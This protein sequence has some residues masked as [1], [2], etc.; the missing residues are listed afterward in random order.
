[1]SVLDRGGRVFLVA[2]AGV[3]HLGDLEFAHRQVDAAAAAGVDAV[4]VQA[5]RT[6]ELVSS[7]AAARLAPDLGHDWYDRLRARELSA[8]GLQEL[9]A[10]AAERGLLFFATP[11]DSS[12]LS[13]VVETLDVPLLKVGSG[14]AVNWRFLR[15]VGA[16]RRPVLASFG[17]ASDEEARR[18]VAT[19]LEAGAPEV[20]ALHTVSVYPTP[21]RLASL[22]RIARLRRLLDVPVGLSDH[23]VGSHV[24]LASVALGVHTL[25]KH[26]TLDKADPRS[27]DNAGALEP[28][29]LA[30]LARQIREIEAALAEPV[31][32][33]LRAALAPA[34]DWALQALVAA[35]DLE[36]GT[37]LR[38]TDLAAKRPARGGI[39]ASELEHVV[40]RTLRR[41]IAVDEQISPADLG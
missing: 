31:D 20:V 29:E 7:F 32:E 27:L 40:G 24:A 17:L 3:S 13:L 14:E 19:L 12:A 34:R 28:D 39:P 35:R 36:A 37:P 26:L 5:W 21:A 15:E 38:C 41:R 1:M 22:G 11:H 25:E 6:D 16:A 10:H 23:T 9:Q 18:A 4:K 2:E 8:A 33:D 30:A